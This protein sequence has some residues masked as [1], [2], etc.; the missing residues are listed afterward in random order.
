MTKT[1]LFEELIKKAERLAAIEAKIEALH[2]MVDTEETRTVRRGYGI[3][4]EIETIRD[5]FG[6]PMCDAARNARIEYEA[7]KARK[8]KEEEE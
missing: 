7:E 2:K 6:W 3:D 1:E 8:A 4:I 5:L